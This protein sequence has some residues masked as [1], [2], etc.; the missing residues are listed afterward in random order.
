M[1]KK[2]NNLI[3]VLITNFNKAKFLNYSIKK[4]KEQEYKNFEIIIF[5][6]CSTDNSL[7]IL[8]SFKEIK[9]IKN[10]KKK[11]KS[12][13][14]NQIYGVLRCF[15]K[16]RG[17]IICLMDADDIFT[18]KKL[19]FINEYFNKNKNAKSLYNLPKTI[20]THFKIRERLNEKIWPS[21]FPTSCISVKR[22][23]FNKFIKF[24]KK[25][26]FSN[27][28]IDARFVIFFKFF[29]NE[30]NFVNKK[31]TSYILDSNGIT[32]NIKK[33][34]KKW[35]LRRLQAYEYMNYVK[36]LKKLNTEISVG[37]IFTKSINFILN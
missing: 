23:S 9:L 6:D 1:I 13:S 20:G 8:K 21:I 12:P 5:D 17:K 19:K 4:L 32:S 28:E 31:L 30:Y 29:F 14:L 24:I 33:F 37:Y 15:K 2:Q 34:S 11:F 25:T 10:R 16:S 18:K 7:E 35:W 3:S 27:L 26:S 22:K 36:K